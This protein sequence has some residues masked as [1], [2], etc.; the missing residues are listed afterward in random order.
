MFG[1]KLVSGEKLT[2]DVFDGVGV[3]SC[4]WWFGRG[5]T[6][7][8]GEWKSEKSSSSSP[9]ESDNNAVEVMEGLGV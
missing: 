8:G 5:L 9:N 3:L 2:L 6:L 1:E 7:I 4:W